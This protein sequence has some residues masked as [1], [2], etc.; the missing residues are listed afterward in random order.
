MLF[1]DPWKELRQEICFGNV[2]PEVVCVAE[3]W[4]CFTDNYTQDFRDMTECIPALAASISYGNEISDYDKAIN[5][6]K[7]LIKRQHLTPLE[8]VQFNFKISGISKICGAQLSRHRIGQGHVSGSRRFRKQS[9]EF[10]YPLIEYIKTREEAET[11]YR[12]IS[13][14]LQYNMDLYN[15]IT[16]GVMGVKKS[17]ARYLIP[18]STATERYWWINVRALRD[19]FRLRLAPDAEWEIRR[20]AFMLLEEVNKRTPSLFEDIYEQY[21]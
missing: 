3:T 5:L 2:E 7:N 12:I 1:N 9:N 13:I 18:T 20:L 16:Q 6:N 8:A 17:D 21:S 14:A 10:V 15:H 11:I 4:P 19:F